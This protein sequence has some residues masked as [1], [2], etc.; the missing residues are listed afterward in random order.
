MLRHDRQAL[1]P[2][3][4]PVVRAEHDTDQAMI[5]LGDEEEVAI[6]R[7][8]ALDLL[9]WN[10][11]EVLGGFPQGEGGVEVVG[12]Q[13]SNV[14]GP[15]VPEAP[16]RAAPPCPLSSSTCSAVRRREAPQVSFTRERV[17]VRKVR[18]EVAQ[19]R[20]PAKA[21]AGQPVEVKQIA[22]QPFET[23]GIPRDARKDLPASVIKTWDG[24]PFE[25]TSYPDAVYINGRAVP[26]R[27]RQTELRDRYL[28]SG[29]TR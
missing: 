4:T 11:A 28:G 2:A 9:A 5:V 7:E 16:L 27:S 10:P 14:H 20:F 22:Q 6:E 21:I 8:D 24:D 17:V 1:D 25:V 26:M 3:T 12:A 15:V 13:R 23:F 29:P 18:P 19:G